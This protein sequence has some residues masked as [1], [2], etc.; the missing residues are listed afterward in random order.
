MG[1]EGGGRGGTSRFP[2]GPPKDKGRVVC[3]QATYPS[4]LARIVR[5]LC[6]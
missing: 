3:A 5:V 4:V 6:T 2:L 1:E